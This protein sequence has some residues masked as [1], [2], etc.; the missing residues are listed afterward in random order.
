MA[1]HGQQVLQGSFRDH[2][3]LEWFNLACDYMN[4]GNTYDHRFETILMSMIWYRWL[5]N[6]THMDHAEIINMSTNI[7]IESS[8]FPCMPPR[9]LELIRH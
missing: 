6:E 3:P 7:Y 8:N 5:I 1:S 4:R 2:L 9:E